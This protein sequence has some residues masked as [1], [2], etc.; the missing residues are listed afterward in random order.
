MTHGFNFS[1]RSGHIILARPF[2]AGYGGP[3]EI[4]RYAAQYKNINHAAL[5]VLPAEISNK[6]TDDRLNGDVSRKLRPNTQVV[7]LNDFDMRI[8]I[9]YY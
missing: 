1:P 3:N 4:C 2:E 5:A 7:E 9:T 8:R 6:E